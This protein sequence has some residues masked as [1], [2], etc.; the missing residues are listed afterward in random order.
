[1]KKLSNKIK[2]SDKILDNLSVSNHKGDRDFMDSECVD[3]CDSLNSIVGITTLESCCGHNYHPYCIW[4]SCDSVEPLTFIQSCIDRRYWEY[5]DQWY[6][7]PVISDTKPFL[8]FILRSK[9]KHLK[10]IMVQVES[11]I[12]SFN[13]YLNHKNRFNFLGQKYENFIFTE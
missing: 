4:F 11:M 8:N 5:G 3:L 1:M 13:Y 7:E 9:S 6:I 12:E 2:Y 10:T